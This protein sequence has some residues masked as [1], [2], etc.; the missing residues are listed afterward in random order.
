VNGPDV[1]R[2]AAEALGQHRRRSALSLLGV[3]IGIIAVITLT[4]LGEG[5]RRF[6]TDQFSALG[7]GLLI[8]M[9]GR[10]ETTGGFPGGGGVPNDLTLNDAITLARSVPGVLQMVPMAM[11]SAPI[12]H[13]ERS[14]QVMVIGSTADFRLVR[15]LRVTSG[16][17]LPPG[18]VESFPPVVVIGRKVARELFGEEDPVGRRVRVG[19]WRMRVLGVLAARGT[20]MGLDMDEAV[21]VPVA[22][23]LRMSNQSSLMRI[24]LKLG[25]HANLDTAKQR[26]IEI[27][28]DRHGEEDITCLTQEAV[29][30]SLTSILRALTLVVVAIAAISLTVA[31]VGIMNVM[32]VSVSERTS[33]VGLLKAL[34]ATRGQILAIFLFEAVLL[35]TAGGAVGLAVGWLMIEAVVAYYPA[36]PASPPVWAV[37]SVIGVSLATGTIF[38]VLPAWRASR[39]DPVAALGGK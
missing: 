12:S 7:T 5:A 4:A 32:L 11:T 2:F 31:G 17:F 10:N 39:L 15:E 14:R 8:V 1:V 26:V 22:A 36:L 23:G 25:P 16:R 34:G 19:D 9:P 30:S 38:G 29:L 18:D 27:I 28:T 21:M 3:S 13:Q 20:Q 6:V 33:E 37:I 35:S 24:L